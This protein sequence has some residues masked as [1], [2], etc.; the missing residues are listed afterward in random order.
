M[1]N[2]L[3]YL[4]EVSF[5]FS[6]LYIVF[7][8]FLRKLT[9]HKVNRVILLI[10]IPLSL[11]LPVLSEVELPFK[12]DPINIS[13]FDEFISIDHLTATNHKDKIIAPRSNMNI[14]DYILILY[15]IGFVIC[16]IRLLAPITRLYTIK[17]KSKTYIKEG[18]HFII[19]DVPAIF[20]F[21]NWIFIPESKINDYEQPIIDHEKVHSKSLHTIDLILTEIYIALHWFNPFVYF[22]KKSIIAVHEFQADQTVINTQIKKSYYLELL[23]KNITAKQSIKLYS[24]FNQSIIKK[25][26]DMITK[27]HSTKTNI[28]RYAVLIPVLLFL[29]MAFTKP[30]HEPEDEF[31][32]T[33][34]QSINTEI[35]TKKPPS[36]FPVKNGSTKD[37]TASFG[38]SF[39]HPIDKK[40]IVH[41]GIDI[42][43][44]EGVPVL[45]T[46]D[47]MIANAS[48]EDDWGNLIVISHA[49]GYETWYAHLQGF[50]IK[51]GEKVKKGQI[52]GY[53]GSTGKS[54]GFHLHYEVRLNKERVN[55]MDYF[56][57]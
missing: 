5:C 48:S 52:I 50:N 42:R 38:K 37:I 17:R 21:F 35:D 46:A 14:I 36:I 34:V 31:D 30:I 1:N 27:N 15:C 12:K 2:Y 10:L 3:I 6:V 41:G 13:G 49:D 32:Y 43:A 25:R 20:S 19:A 51:N 44:K 4:L 56:K 57:K 29:L 16:T 8:L 28:I 53:V 26:I 33:I 47:G 24:Y 40:K 18:Y 55:P 9:F 11:I 23:F 39:T 7:Y 45:A 54:T 22:F